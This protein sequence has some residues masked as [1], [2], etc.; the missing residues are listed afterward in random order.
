MSCIR[1][2]LSLD[3]LQ[4]DRSMD[5]ASKRDAKPHLTSSKR[6]TMR[7][8]VHSFSSFFCLAG[9]FVL[10][11][12]LHARLFIWSFIGCFGHYLSQKHLIL[13]VKKN[14]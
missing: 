4:T 13:L 1:F 11:I 14:A 7:L 2:L 9:S 3:G 8:H 12:N 5:K 6:T 10:F